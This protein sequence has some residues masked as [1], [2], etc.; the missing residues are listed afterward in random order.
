MD[1][2]I[3]R[4]RD[5]NDAVTREI[6]RLRAEAPDCQVVVV[7]YQDK[8]LPGDSEP[9]KSVFRYGR[10]DLESLPYPRKV[11]SVDWK[12]PTG[13]HDLPVL[14]YFQDNPGF[15]YYWVIEDDVRWSGNW[16]DFFADLG[17]SRADFLGTAMQRRAANPN[18]HWWTTL[19]TGGETVAPEHM[20]K[21][22]GPVIRASAAGLRAIDAK[23]RAGW[24]GHFELIWPTACMAAGLAA[25]DIGG[26]GEF[27]PQDRR[28]RFYMNNV[29]TWHLFP[30]TFVFRPAFAETGESRY[31]SGFFSRS[32][33]WHPIKN[34]K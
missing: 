2:I 16:Q 23:Y 17:K 7:A 1:V 4:T 31:G 32:M 14:K 33:L 6:A 19:E 27:T 15:D 30:G 8:Y 20:V 12:H 29:E 18:W 34:S 28:D 13:H 9:E 11:K 25:E 24:T 10:G 26:T 3:Y 5:V 21:C 22:F